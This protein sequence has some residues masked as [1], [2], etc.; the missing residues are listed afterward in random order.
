M[1]TFVLG[2]FYT[3]LN[4][5]E[6]YEFQFFRAYGNIFLTFWFV[7]MFFYDKKFTRMMWCYALL[8]YMIWNG[9]LDYFNTYKNQTIEADSAAD[10]AH[11]VN[12]D[13]TYMEGYDKCYM[14]QYIF[15][16]TVILSALTIYFFFNIN[17][18]LACYTHWQNY[19]AEKGSAKD[20]VTEL[21]PSDRSGKV[22]AS[23]V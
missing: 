23:N 6:F 18:T 9:I 19:D 12:D 8:G 20:A 7:L 14:D 22:P 3:L 15:R 11:L 5:Y 13:G 21:T 2:W 16:N 4:L 1:G 10:C 17:W